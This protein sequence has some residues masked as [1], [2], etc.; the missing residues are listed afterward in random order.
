MVRQIQPR[1]F[2]IRRVLALAGLGVYCST[3]RWASAQITFPTAA[4]G[5]GVVRATDYGVIPN[6]GLDDTAAINSLL[7]L[8]G[9]NSSQTIY[10]P[11]GVY[12]LSGTILPDLTTSGTPSQTFGQVKRTTLQ[13]QSW[14]GTVFRLATGSFTDAA[15]PKPVIDFNRGANVAQAF[16]N[17]IRDLTI[18]VQPNNAGAVGI[19]FNSNNTGAMRSVKPVDS[20]N[21]ALTG[22]RLN[23]AENG[24]LWIKDLEVSG[25]ATG[26]LT[27]ENINSQTMENITL[28]NQRATG[29][30]N[31]LSSGGRQALAI[32]NL[33]STNSVTAFH[34]RFESPSPWTTIIDANL[35]GTGTASTKTAVYTAGAAY[36]RGLTTSGYSKAYDMKWG[37]P[38]ISSG[39]G[40]NLE[41][42][43]RYS[44]SSGFK[45]L[46]P[47]AATGLN[48]PIRQTPT[49]PWGD[50]ATQWAAPVNGP[51][52]DTAAIQAVID[53]PGVKTVYLTRGTWTVGGTLHLRG[54]VERVIGLGAGIDGGGTVQVDD[55]LPATVLIE[56]LFQVTDSHLKL[57]HNTARTLVVQDAAFEFYS[58][59][60]SGTGDL[61]VEN[62]VGS[63]MAITAQQAWLKQMNLEPWTRDPYG[64]GAYLVND[65]GMVS[66]LG[67]KTE[68]RGSDAFTFV[69]TKNGGQTELLGGLNYYNAGTWAANMPAYEVSEASF[70]LSILNWFDPGG[71]NG[72]SILIRQTEQGA[73][74]T[75]GPI[76]QSYFVAR[77]VPE[78]GAI[79]SILAVAVICRCKR[80]R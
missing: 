39:N 73:T 5:A 80:G 50:V 57:R 47:T 40:S 56:R 74:L 37:T 58:N 2:L 20:G 45:M 71:G 46:F 26:V 24:P 12:D 43:A 63:Q 22:V 44:G 23:F 72:P 36:I 61:F 16:N 38:I 79:L 27:A 49:V 14:E 19:N 70:G 68:Y 53:T 18:Q 11:D 21:T 75:T 51:G 35:A 30:Q 28:V 7:D 3:A 1:S 54:S 60:P 77:H 31:G 8:V 15:N 17:Y 4:I 10:F 52:D 25:F 67:L 32:H 59:T 65:G 78:P 76:P 66:I 9:N 33:T 69:H 6:D 42:A 41:A 62:Y 29:I 13:G 34:A 55:G 64:I 48:L